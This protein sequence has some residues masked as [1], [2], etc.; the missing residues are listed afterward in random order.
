VRRR[1]Y[2]VSVEERLAMLAEEEAA[3]AR[4]MK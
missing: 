2:R 1:R 4:L 3:G